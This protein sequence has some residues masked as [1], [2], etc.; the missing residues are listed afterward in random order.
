MRP[1]RRPSRH[2]PTRAKR[3]NAAP[4][5]RFRQC[6]P[7]RRFA[8]PRTTIISPL[9]LVTTPHRTDRR[10][11]GGATLEARACPTRTEGP[12][13]FEPAISIADQ[14]CPAHPPPPDIPPDLRR[15]RCSSRKDARDSTPPTGVY[16]PVQCVFPPVV[17]SIRAVHASSAPRSCS[18]DCGGRLELREWF[19]GSRSST[20]KARGVDAVHWEQRVEYAALTDIGFRR[21]NNQDSY[22]VL[23]S[24]SRDEWLD[25]GHVFLVADG[26]GG[27]AVGELAS[28]IAADT[29]PHTFLKLR[30]LP[31]VEALRSAVE[32]AHR[33][34][35]ERGEQNATSTA[36]GPPARP[37]SSRPWE[38]WSGM[39][40]TAA[41]IA[42]VREKSNNSRS[43]TACNGS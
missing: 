43:T 41:V 37:W 30:E 13:N 25:R 34:I 31:V 17:S 40:A 23:T 16:T 20:N 18:M 3:R 26:M 6:P 24:K 22:C 42:F 21:R 33:V 11:R 39:S 32:T 19:S 8:V 2:S 12:A 36:W 35:H 15:L 28:K 27:H 10:G 9:L 5:R 14:V 1:I 4:L 7:L 38:R 29:V